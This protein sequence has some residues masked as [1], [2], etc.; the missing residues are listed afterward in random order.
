MLSSEESVLELLLS[1]V[2]GGG[3]L[4]S[5]VPTREETL[6]SRHSSPVCAVLSDL[7]TWCLIVQ[8]LP[9]SYPQHS[10]HQAHVLPPDTP[11]PTLSGYG[12]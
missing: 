9:G 3:P 11:S 2:P 7:K 5:A 6:N 10:P 1:E 4:G 8:S 12:W